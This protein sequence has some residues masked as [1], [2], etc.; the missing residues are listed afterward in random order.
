[1]LTIPLEHERRGNMSG[2]PQEGFSDLSVKRE[3]FVRLD[4]VVGRGSFREKCRRIVAL[5][6]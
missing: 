5:P 4:L 1:M 2:K 3:D 6:C